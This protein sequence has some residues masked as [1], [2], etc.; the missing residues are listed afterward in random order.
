MPLDNMKTFNHFSSPIYI[1]HKEEF[2]KSTV[3]A[4]DKIIKD[5]RKRD[6]KKIKQTNDFGLSYHSSQLLG[7]T[8]FI[9]L[10]NYLG[11]V[12]YKFLAEQG[13]DVDF[14]NL[15]F[16]DF[17][18][19]EFAK[20]GGGHQAAHQHQNSHVSGFYFLKCSDKTSHPVFLDPRPGANMTKLKLKENVLCPGS[21]TVHFHPQPGNLIVFPSYLL[22]EFTVDHGRDTFRFIHFNLQAV[23]SNMINND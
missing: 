8:N 12:S 9:D 13:Y 16:T 14:Y 2:L 22:H 4:T 17:W 1:E 15:M 6:S 21:E 5:A 7:D 3:K 20:N 11:Q 10:R 18:V 19:Q 23:P